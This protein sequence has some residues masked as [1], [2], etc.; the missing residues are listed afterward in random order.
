VLSVRGGGIDAARVLGSAVE[1]KARANAALNLSQGRDVEFAVAFA[2]ATLG[3]MPDSQKLADDLNRQF[4][5]DTSVQYQY[6][7][8]LR[9]LAALKE[10]DAPKARQELKSAERYE[11]AIN[12]LSENGFY[13]TM[14]SA[15]V[16]VEAFLAEGNGVKAAA[17]FQKLIDHGGLC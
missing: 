10:G 3:N 8:V 12:G 2:Q 14:Y 5:E 6:L 4:R 15:Y 1:A 16:R 7:P 11:T 17:E 13:G 9:A